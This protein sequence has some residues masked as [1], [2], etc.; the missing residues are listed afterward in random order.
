ML[1]DV[2]DAGNGPGVGVFGM[3]SGIRLEDIE[4]GTQ[5]T[6]LVGER[7]LTPQGQHGAIWMRSVN[8]HGDGGD[9]FAVT[10]ICHQDAPL[11]DA[12]QGSGFL[13]YHPGGA[14]FAMA[15]GAIRFIS[16]EIEGGLYEDLAQIRD[17]NA[18]TESSFP[19]VTR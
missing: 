13:S 18:L 6:L 4:D 16:E 11:N 17:G 15:D 5:F 10:G 3:N 12:S 1:G 19:A 9:G 7:S 2:P 14:Q 8:R